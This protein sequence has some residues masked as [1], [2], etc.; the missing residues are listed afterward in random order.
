MLLF[1]DIRD[2]KTGFLEPNH[3]RTEHRNLPKH[4]SGPCRHTFVHSAGYFCWAASVSAACC[5]WQ[6]YLDRFTCNLVL[7][8]NCCA[9]WL[10]LSSRSSGGHI[11]KI[12][13]YSKL[14]SIKIC[15]LIPFCFVF[16]PLYK[17]IWLTF[18]IWLSFLK[19]ICKHRT[20]QQRRR[21]TTWTSQS[22]K[23]CN[24]ALNTLKGC[25]PAIGTRPWRPSST[26]WWRPRS[27]SFVIMPSMQLSFVAGLSVLNS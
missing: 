26:D 23:P 13:C 2:A 10:P 25:W 16:F 5:G 9:D 8:C 4:S 7:T 20:W 22:P 24:T 14:L 27:E 12:W 15:W 3:R 17:I 19:I 18:F 1:S 11:L 6:R 21:T